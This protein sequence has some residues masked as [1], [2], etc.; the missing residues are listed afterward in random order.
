MD[1]LLRVVNDSLLSDTLDRWPRVLFKRATDPD[2]NGLYND[3]AMNDIFD[4]L[5]VIATLKRQLSEAHEALRPFANAA[6]GFSDGNIQLEYRETDNEYY[7]LHT[8]NE[9]LSPLMTQHLMNAAKVLPCES[10]SQA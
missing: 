8:D 3:I 1:N 2:F 6:N 10:K 4:A 5:D 9:A 7:E